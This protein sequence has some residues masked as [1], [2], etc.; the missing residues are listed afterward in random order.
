MPNK[1]PSSN[2]VAKTKFPIYTS[3]FGFRIDSFAEGII[4]IV[5]LL[6]MIGFLFYL[7]GRLD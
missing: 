3:I 4:Y 2:R 7:M 6:I 5:W 1:Q